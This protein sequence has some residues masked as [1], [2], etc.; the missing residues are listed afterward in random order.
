MTAVTYALSSNCPRFGSAE[1]SCIH[2]CEQCRK[3]HDDEAFWSTPP[4]CN[5]PTRQAG[6]IWNLNLQI[7]CSKFCT[8]K[9]SSSPEPLVSL[10]EIV[11]LRRSD[12]RTGR[13][14]VAQIYDMHSSCLFYESTLGVQDILEL[15]AL[16]QKRLPVE[17]QTTIRL[18]YS[19]PIVHST[20]LHAQVSKIW[21]LDAL[22]DQ[23][24][25]YEPRWAIRIL[26]VV[27]QAGDINRRSRVCV[28]SKCQIDIS[29]VTPYHHICSYHYT[30]LTSCVRLDSRCHVDIK[31][32][33]SGRRKLWLHQQASI[34]AK[35]YLKQISSLYC[36]PKSNVRLIAGLRACLDN[37][38]IMEYTAHRDSKDSK[39][40]H[41]Y[42]LC[43]LST[44]ASDCLITS[45]LQGSQEVCFLLQTIAVKSSAELG[46][47]T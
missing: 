14:K 12:K 6:G 2:F 36:I 11:V 9:L 7:V 35:H 42:E 13:P 20:P 18:L 22:R 17:H 34:I 45:C 21:S 23:A 1:P 3:A 10:H 31:S 41:L 33:S 19:N 32:V 28:R 40:L 39:C 25:Y 29:P 44:V 24:D 4:P 30:G 43:R 46:P 8:Y 37:L 38:S 26:V 16:P 5:L 27:I 15:E 47:C